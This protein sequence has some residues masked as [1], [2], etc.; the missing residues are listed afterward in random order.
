MANLNAPKLLSIGVQFE[1]VTE[2][3]PTSTPPQDIDG[4][5]KQWRVNMNV[6]ALLHSGRYSSRPFQYD[7]RDIAVGM[8]IATGS[9]AQIF[10]IDE[11]INQNASQVEC[12]VSDE[13]KLNALMD[14]RQDGNVYIQ[15]GPGIAFEVKQRLP[16]LFP[17]PAVLPAN[18]SRGFATQI[19]NRFL[20]RERRDT[21]A[22]NQPG[23]TMT[24]KTAVVLN[25][26]GQYEAVD[27]SAPVSTMTKRIIGVVEE[28]GWPTVD[29]FRIRTIGPVVDIMLG[30]APGTLYFIDGNSTTGQLLN[31]DPNSTAQQ[32][33]SGEPVYIVIDDYTAVFIGGGLFDNTTSTTVYTV[34]DQN[35]LGTIAGVPGDTAFVTDS[36][37]LLGSGE[38]AY[39]IYANGGWVLLSTED[40][41]GSQKSYKTTVAWNDM[42]TKLIHRVD[43]N[44]RVMNVS[45]EVTQPFNGGATLTV[46]DSNDIDRHMTVDENDLSELGTYYSFPNH[47]YQELSEVHV[48][49]YLTKGNATQGSAEVLITYV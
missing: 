22:I 42:N 44:V 31:L 1:E 20:F 3:W 24:K 46:G 21:L 25:N 38:W 26:T 14:D 29:D 15:E 37:N 39:Y 10:R 16:I 12:K 48:N 23:H 33:I 11:I 19:L 41:A 36:G 40:A 49:A 43:H 9:N 4:M 6:N 13:D 7:G 27:F 8:Y 32:S 17:L 18:F 34:A 28:V 45:V 35:E 47:L 30:G 2:Y 5:P